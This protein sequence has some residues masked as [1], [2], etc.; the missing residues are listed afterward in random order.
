MFYNFLL[1][2]QNLIFQIYFLL[3]VNKSK[4]VT[5][6]KNIV[7]LLLV[8]INDKVVNMRKIMHLTLCINYFLI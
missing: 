2:P 8:D 4:L 5:K 7:E 1:V 3:F 6:Y